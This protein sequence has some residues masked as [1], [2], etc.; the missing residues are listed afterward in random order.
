MKKMINYIWNID[1]VYQHATL[2][3][4]E[5]DKLR[6]EIE[7]ANGEANRVVAYAENA[8][9]RIAGTLVATD[10]WVYEKSSFNQNEY[11]VVRGTVKAEEDDDHDPHDHHVFMV[12]PDLADSAQM[13][14]YVFD[15]STLKTCTED[16]LE[17][18]QRYHAG[19]LPIRYSHGGRY[20]SGGGP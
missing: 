20:H 19:E 6:L 12:F 14:G 3:A 4:A 16:I 1:A 13:V 18:I 15:Q 17:S 7:P 9:A 11:E 8:G 5:G 10:N 2:I